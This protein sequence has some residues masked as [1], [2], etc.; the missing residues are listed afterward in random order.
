M[1][2]IKSLLLVLLS[3][4]LVGT[5]IYH[6]Y[7]K[8]V[9]T[10]LITEVSLKDSVRATN[11]LRDSLTNFYT[12]TIRNLDFQLDSSRNQADSIRFNLD[13]KLGEINLLKTEI[14]YILNNR[15]AT[16]NDLSTARVKIDELQQ[17]VN[18]LRGQNDSMEDEKLKLSAALDHLNNEMKTLEKNI[19][20]LNQ[21]NKDMA[22][23]INDASSFFVSEMKFM[24]V[25]VRN[26]KEQETKV[27]A[28]A[29]KFVSSFIL[30]NNIADYE[31]TEITIIIAD[32][33]GQVI[34]NPVWDSGKFTTKKDG[35]K[36]Y[37]RKLK[38]DYAKGE[39]KEIIFSIDTDQYEKGIYQMQIYHNGL[40]IAKTSK[41]L[42]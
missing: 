35:V 14:S 21:E 42:K 18:E 19:R 24:A 39:Q 13:R 5:W 41:T 12:G 32:P 8:T 1:K 28:K 11:A 27:A 20:N 29:N 3:T 17:K 7:D 37:T 33:T 16:K 2:D 30:K 15:N 31:N 23:K 10:N 38:F 36:S 22:E 25:S 26:N 9:Y 34:Q 40:L 6:L 4:G